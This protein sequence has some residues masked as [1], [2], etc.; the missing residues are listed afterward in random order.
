MKHK[1]TIAFAVVLV[2]ILVLLV[3]GCKSDPPPT[4][5]TRTAEFL[6]EVS[7][8]LGRLDTIKFTGVETTV[9]RAESSRIT[10]WVSAQNPNTG[11]KT[12]LRFD[13]Q[14]F[15]VVEKRIQ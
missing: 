3:A 6:I 14:H 13:I 1:N 4:P 12:T 11:K 9:F 10:R 2:S 15:K 5:P 8:T 7:D